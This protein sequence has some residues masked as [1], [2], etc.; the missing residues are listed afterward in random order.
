MISL[1][2]LHVAD[3]QAFRWCSLAGVRQLIGLQTLPFFIVNR[4]R[5]CGIEELGGLNN[6]KGGLKNFGLEDV[7][8]LEEARGAN[9]NK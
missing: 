6:L 5:G 7:R 1:R 9:L 2:H 8:N 3:A 4:N